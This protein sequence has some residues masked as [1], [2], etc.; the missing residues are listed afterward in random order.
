MNIYTDEDLKW[1]NPPAEDYLSIHL[2]R[3]RGNVALK[4]LVGRPKGV[5]FEIFK[6]VKWD[7]PPME[8]CLLID[9]LRSRGNVSLD[10]SSGTP[11]S[12]PL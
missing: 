6:G 2:L 12:V 11:E 7:K 9:L 10:T 8:V 1:D 4:S 3:S 5:P